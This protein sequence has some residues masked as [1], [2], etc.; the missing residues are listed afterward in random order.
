MI[1]IKHFLPSYIYK[2]IG[3][4]KESFL[5]NYN[6][7]KSHLDD[8]RLFDTDRLCLQ[9]RYGIYQR[10]LYMRGPSI[11]V[12]IIPTVNTFLRL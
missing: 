7:H 5:P 9:R 3:F 12:S 10:Y 4:S 11:N 1:I 2:T 8:G 6:V